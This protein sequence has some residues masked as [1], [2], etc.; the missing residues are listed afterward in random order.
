MI[1]EFRQ[2]GERYTLTYEKVVNQ[3]QKHDADVTSSE[4]EDED[5][6]DNDNGEEMNCDDA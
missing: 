4:E 1:Q 2:H 5:D 3:A 6:D